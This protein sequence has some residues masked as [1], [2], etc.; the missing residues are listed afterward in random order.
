MIRDSI[1]S[2]TYNPLSVE[3]GISLEHLQMDK[4]PLPFFARYCCMG[5]L[6]ICECYVVLTYPRAK[7]YPASVY[8]R[9][10]NSDSQTDGQDHS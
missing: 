9:Y 10:I 5:L 4:W 2:Q 6:R 3:Y 8:S 1:E 7:K